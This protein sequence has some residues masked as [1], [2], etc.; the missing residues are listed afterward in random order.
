M[1]LSLDEFRA[2]LKAGEAPADAVVTAPSQGAPKPVSGTRRVKFVFSDGS[3]DRSGDTVDPAGW[4]LTSFQKN[5]V[6]LFGHDATSIE[7]IMGKAVNFAVS[8]NRLIGEIDFAD[9]SINPRADMCYRMVRA[10]LLNAVSVGFM[11]LDFAFAKGSGRA[12]GAIDFKSQQLLE[13]SICA[14]P[15]NAN[16]L[17]QRSLGAAR[18]LKRLSTE[19]LLRVAHAQRFLASCR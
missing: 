14:V 13:I 2:K 15:A 4:D 12:P 8:G 5:P 18:S 19:Q 3:I 7:N 9:S 17:A 1:K 6:A 11:P 10:G 16:A